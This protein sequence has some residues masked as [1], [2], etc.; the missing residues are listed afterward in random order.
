MKKYHPSYLAGKLCIITLTFF[1]LSA[2]NDKGKKIKNSFY[3]RG[4]IKIEIS[5]QHDTLGVLLNDTA[6]SS[7]ADMNAYMNDVVKMADSGFKTMGYTPAGNLKNNPDIKLIIN[8]KKAVT[9]LAL[10]KQVKQLKDNKNNAYIAN[11]GYLVREKKTNEP[12]LVTDEILVKFKQGTSDVTANQLFQSLGLL[13]QKKHKQ[14]S[15]L[16]TVVTSPQSQKDVLTLSHTLNENPVVEYADINFIH[17]KEFL[18]VVPN[19]AMFGE[20]WTLVN[21]RADATEDADIDADKAW[22]FSMGDPGI[23][24]AIIDVA[25]DTGHEDLAGN[26]SHNPGEVPDNRVD[27]DNNGHVDDI[28]GW[29]FDGDNNILDD[30]GAHGTAVTGVAN[31]IA[32]NGIGVTGSCPRCKTILLKSGHT[33]EADLSAF[34][35]AIERN[36]KI[37]NCSWQYGSDAPPSIADVIQH[38]I[39]NGITVVASMSNDSIDY[40]SKSPLLAGIK[41]LIL[42]SRSS[43]LDSYDNSGLGNCMTVLAPTGVY[44]TP[45]GYL[46]VTT[47]DIRGPIG[48]ND[49]TNETWGC[50]PPCSDP[51][52]TNCFWGTSA[53]APLTSGVAGLI[54]SVQPELSPQQVKNL[55]QD[56][57]DKIEHSKAVYDTKNGKSISNTHGFGRLNAYE[58]V[59]IASPD[60]SNGGGNGV[61]IFFR[62][63]ELDWGNTEKP[64]SYSFE[65]DRSGFLAYWKSLDIKVDAPPYTTAPAVLDNIF[66][67]SLTDESPVG[68]QDNRVYVRMRNR[69]FKPANNVSVKL[70]WVHAGAGLPPLPSDFWSRFPAD[71]L[72]TSDWNTVGIQTISSI[73]YSGPSSLAVPGSTDL[74]AITRFTFSAPVHDPS[75]RNHYC[76]MAIISSGDDP[77]PTARLVGDPDKLNMDYVTKNFNN[78]T[79]RNYNIITADAPLAAEFMLYNPL[80]YTIYSSLE[81]NYKGSKIPVSISDSLLTQKMRLKPGEKKKVLMNINPA[82]LKAETEIEIRQIAETANKGKPFVIG[83]INYLIKPPDKSPKK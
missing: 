10:D 1:S 41:D 50:F 4:D 73:S 43:S 11:A 24:M 33:L 49:G 39:N 80:P 52:Y 13:I 76:L 68:G 67:E 79:H 5:I 61:D 74:A 47:A 23:L 9:F 2:C 75:T 8:N 31:A 69:G 77:M 82:G 78:A 25:F 56:C 34:I 60:I 63:N 45:A 65:P 14:L 42:V 30:M 28:I 37:I 29:N 54:L 72:V 15:Q 62:D 22:D 66:F 83:G 38:A 17:A 18:N 3:Y 71:P 81:V 12:L 59:R 40:C 55:I 36:V 21:S 19:D 57:A 64:S 6:L 26:F 51:D 35:Y 7:S 20:L 27:D 16:Y 53:S 48:Y 70:H 32:D 44:G 58:A 46:K